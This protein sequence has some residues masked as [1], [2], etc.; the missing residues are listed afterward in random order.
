M[1]T[2]LITRLIDYLIANAFY[3]EAK[4][5]AKTTKNTGLDDDFEKK[6]EDAGIKKE[7]VSD[8]FSKIRKEKYK[9][10]KPSG[11]IK[12]RNFRGVDGSTNYRSAQ[13][14]LEKD[15]FIYLKEEYG[16]KNVL[17]LRNEVKSKNG[18][19]EGQLVRDA[20]LNYEHVHLTSSPPNDSQWEKITALL[21][22][23]NTL[24]HCQHGADRTGA[25]VARYKVENQSANREDALREAI[26]Y[27]FKEETHKGYGKG[28]DPNRKLREWILK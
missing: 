27:G 8:E 10:W 23:G 21:N 1:I 19:P 25:I 3:D 9:K 14:P 5:L 11:E 15:F 18:E 22:S 6:I 28:P 24:I 13:P 2:Y 26:G 7:D 12:Y 17:N 20:G 16:I 4:E